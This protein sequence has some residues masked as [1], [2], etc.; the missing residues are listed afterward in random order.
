MPQQVTNSLTLQTT[1]TKVDMWNSIRLDFELLQTRMDETTNAPPSPRRGITPA[2]HRETKQTV[3][4]KSIPLKL[5][6]SSNG[7]TVP[8]PQS[9]TDARNEATILSQLNHPNILKLHAV[10]ESSTHIVL[11]TEYCD[12]GDLLELLQEHGGSL[13]EDEARY[14]FRQIASALHH[15]HSNGIAHRDIKV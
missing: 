8:D 11:I 14:I 9:R 1:N 7:Q 3:C 13:S 10:H 12:G 4:I 6:S 15:C 2:V 5:L